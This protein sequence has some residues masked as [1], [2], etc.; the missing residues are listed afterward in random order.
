VRRVVTVG[1][2]KSAAGTGGQIPMNSDLFAVL[3]AHLDWFTDRFERIEPEH[4]F[5]VNSATNSARPMGA[6]T[7][8]L[9]PPRRLALAVT[10]TSPKS[11]ENGK[12]GFAE[13]IKRLD[14]RRRRS[15]EG[16]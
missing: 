12:I 7:H 1:K 5:G 4:R 3:S 9:R 10:S 11:P 16:I 15:A 6:R 13:P 2:A 14:I 8:E